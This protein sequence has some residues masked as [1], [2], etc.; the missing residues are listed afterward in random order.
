MISFRGA[1]AALL[2]VIGAPALAHL[3]PNSETRLAFGRDHVMADIIIPQGEYAAATGNPTGNDR[4]SRQRAAAYLRDTIHVRASDGRDWQMSLQSLAFQQIAGPPDLHAIMRLSPPAGASVRQ[5]RIDWDAVI[6]AQ[7]NHFVLFVAAADFAGGKVD[8]RARILGALQGARRSLAIDRGDASLWNGFRAAVVLGMHHIAQGR[9][10]LLFL[11]TLLLPAPLLAVGGRW[12]G[13]R[14]PA[15][16][17]RHLFAI[18]TAFTI[19]HSI[20]LI[21]VAALGWRLAAPPVEIAIALT[22]LI[23]AAH[24]WRPVFPGR[25]PMVAGGFG[26]IH[27]LA[28][29]GV[30]AGLGIDRTEKSLA[31]LG[32][33]IGIE[34]VQIVVVAVVLPVFLLLARSPRAAL[35]RTTG[36]AFAAIAAGAW[37]AERIT[38][39]AN[40]ITALLG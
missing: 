30:V 15:S 34:L 10:H 19:G 1:F 21:M 39:T 12:Q 37:L 24:A 9:D 11:I 16:A 31:I 6:A 7:P 25:E 26:L 38:G 2:L 23:A 3:T 36:A 20:T 22:I 13:R 28:F 29:A 4:Q 14:T 33:N 32:F 18:V 35:W 8:D 17:F 40:P 27:G 5:L